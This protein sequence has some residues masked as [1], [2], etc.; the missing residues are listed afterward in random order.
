VTQGTKKSSSLTIHE[1]GIEGETMQTHPNK[2]TSTTEGF[3]F[4]MA[5]AVDL[6]L[7]R[8]PD[9]SQAH[10]RVSGLGDSSNGKTWSSAFASTT[11]F[12][13]SSQRAIRDNAYV[14]QGAKESSPL[15]IHEN[16]VEEKT[17]Q[18]HHNQD[19][20]ST[21]GFNFKMVGAV[22]LWPVRFPTSSQAH[23]RVSGFDDS[24]NGKTWSSA[25]AS[26]IAFAPSTH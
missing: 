4:K 25:F 1:E 15:T 22:D 20:S 11:A 6:W 9:S 7:A 26:I 2:D 19:T 5:D 18:T 14:T 8:F 17:M 24:S 10:L 13:P 21:E 23:F 16:C 12:A 3:N